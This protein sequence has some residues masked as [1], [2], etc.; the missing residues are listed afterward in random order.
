MI[1]TPTKE[2]VERYSRCDMHLHSIG[3]KEYLVNKDNFNSKTVNAVKWLVKFIDKMGGKNKERGPWELY[4]RPQQEPKDL[5]DRAMS[6]GMDFF[7]LTDHD[8]IEGWVKLLNEHPELE[9]V[10]HRR[11]P[12]W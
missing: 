9:G 7:C 6:N 1:A 10:H 5:F 3:S 4:H 2:E 12:A 8:S 11:G